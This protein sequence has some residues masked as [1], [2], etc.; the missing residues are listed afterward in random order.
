MYECAKQLANIPIDIAKQEQSLPKSV[1]FLEMYN[2]GMVEQLNILNRWKINDP[3]KSLAA[4]VGFDKTQELFKL[5]NN[6]GSK[7]TEKYGVRKAPTL[8]VPTKDNNVEY[9]ENASDI[10]RFIEGYKK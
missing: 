9:Y 5:D 8:I 1:T 3:T 6:I 7:L 10:K 2:V 4:P